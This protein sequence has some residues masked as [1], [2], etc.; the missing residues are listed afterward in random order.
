MRFLAPLTRSLRLLGFPTGARGRAWGMR[1]LTGNL[2]GAASAWLRDCS[3]SGL[4]GERGGNNRSEANECREGQREVESVS[5]SRREL[6]SRGAQAQ[7]PA[8]RQPSRAKTAGVDGPSAGFPADPPPA[9][10]MLMCC[11]GDGIRLSGAVQ[12]EARGRAAAAMRGTRQQAAE[13]RS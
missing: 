6:L 9:L 10:F 7:R 11:E 1:I 8:V 4:P 3:T 12:L 2:S 5:S 13:G